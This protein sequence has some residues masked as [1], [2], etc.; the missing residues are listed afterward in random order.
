MRKLIWIFFTLGV[1]G[2]YLPNSR[3]LGINIT[4]GDFS[5]LL[6]FILIFIKNIQNGRT[7]L[8]IK[9]RNPIIAISLF[10]IMLGSILSFLKSTNIFESATMLLQYIFIFS[11]LLYVLNYLLEKNIEKSTLLIL[12]IATVPHVVIQFLNMLSYMGIFNLFDYI[13]ISGSGRYVGFY[14]NANALGINATMSYVFL[15]LFFIYYS[16]LKKKLLIL[17]LIVLSLL[18]IGLSA[19][20]GSIIL[21]ALITIIIILSFNL[22]SK[23]YIIFLLLLL[24]LTVI[25]FAI[26]FSET[27]KFYES[28][29][30]GK[31]VDRINNS[32]DDG[33]GSSNLRMDLN[34]EGLSKFKESPIVGIGFSEFPKISI[35]KQTVHN[36]LIV[37]AAEVG[38]FGF[39]GIA[40]LLI[41]PIIISKKLMGSIK[42]RNFKVIMIFLHIYSLFRLLSIATSGHFIS[43]EPWIPVLCIIIIYSYYIIDSKSKKRKMNSLNNSL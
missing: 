42:D 17:I 16:D 22:K 40:I 18:S 26:N 23:I 7:N 5:Y 10:L 4:Y 12:I 9:R 34:K 21:L 43:R 32:E 3:P 2:T 11:I 15:V 39:L 37:T 27:T 31:L 28:F 36:T 30:P 1:F 13:L 41:Y 8:L 33:V 29:L 38:I 35:Y 19:S 24:F 6:C 25:F 14:G 20:F